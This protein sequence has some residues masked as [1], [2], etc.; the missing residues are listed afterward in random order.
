MVAFKFYQGACAE[1][2]IK[3]SK[4]YQLKL[5]LMNGEKLS[6]TEKNWITEQ[7]NANISS[8]FGIYVSGWYIGFREYLKGFYVTQ[9]GHTVIRYGFDK[10]AIRKCTYGRI[11]RLDEFK[12]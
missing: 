3:P 9:Y 12:I 2:Q 5:R 1:E 6:R 11:D 8:S 4:A 7:I 10:T